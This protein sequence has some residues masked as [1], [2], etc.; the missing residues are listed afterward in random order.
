MQKSGLKKLPSFSVIGE[1]SAALQRQQA[2][3]DQF[4]L[5]ATQLTQ[6]VQ[7]LMG[8][9]NHVEAQISGFRSDLVKKTSSLKAVWDKFLQRVANRGMVL[10]GAL[11]FY[12]AKEEVLTATS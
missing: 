3:F 6:Q 8:S 10:S 5:E 2:L 11:A 1:D 9:A 4:Q 7:E 12:S